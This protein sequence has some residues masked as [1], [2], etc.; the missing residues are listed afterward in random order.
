MATKVKRQLK[1]KACKLSRSLTR[2]ETLNA[3]NEDEDGLRD[4]LAVV[5]EQSKSMDDLQEELSGLIPEEDIETELDTWNELEERK[6]QLTC[7]TRKMIKRNSSQTTVVD[8]TKTAHLEPIKIPKFSGQAAQYE[9]FRAAFK[10]FVDENGHISMMEKMIRL[11]GYLEGEALQAIEGLTFSESDYRAA[12]KILDKRFGGQNRQ[13]NERL[14]TLR[15]QE[16]IIPGDCNALRRFADL[17]T[18][19]VLSLKN[20]GDEHD[21]FSETLFENVFRKLPENDR[22]SF[23]SESIKSGSE[24]DL[25]LQLQGD[26]ERRNQQE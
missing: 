11:K 8:A 19:T 25:T 7:E 15:C 18:A 22:E 10:V 13:L 12:L 3:R 5:L 16:S 23:I 2:L 20:M 26:R 21:I 4:A 24:M 14:Q 1:A 6:V 9:Q 17:L